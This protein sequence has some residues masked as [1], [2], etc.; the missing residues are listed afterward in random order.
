MTVDALMDLVAEQQWSKADLFGLRRK[1]YRNEPAAPEEESYKKLK[2]LYEQLTPLPTFETL[3]TPI[4]ALDLDKKRKRKQ[5]K[6][7][8]YPLYKKSCSTTS[9]EVCRRL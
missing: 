7:S 4:G 9:E 1:I 8:N 3:Q 6:V 2:D 5:A